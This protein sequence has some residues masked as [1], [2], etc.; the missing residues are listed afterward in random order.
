MNIN[1]DM[2]L[3]IPLLII[4]TSIVNTLLFGKPN[5]ENFFTK[6]ML[7]RQLN[8]FYQLKDLTIHYSNAN[9]KLYF[10]FSFISLLLLT[11]SI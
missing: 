6:A 3:M 1:F 4:D 5:S 8:L 11:R 2:V 9:Q 7:A 10:A